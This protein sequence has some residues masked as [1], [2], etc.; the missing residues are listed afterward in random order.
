MGSIILLAVIAP[1]LFAADLAEGWRKLFENKIREAHDIFSEASRSTDRSKAAEAYRGLSEIS[2]F[3]GAERDAAEQLLRAYALDGNR[4]AVAANI[5]RLASFTRSAEGASIKSGYSLLKKLSARTDIYTGL[6]QERLLERYRN[7][8]KLRKARALAAEMGIANQWY[9]IGPFDNI[10]DNGYHTVYPPERRIDLAGRYEGKDGNQVG[11][12]RLEADPYAGWL[13]AEEYLPARGAVNY[14]YTSFDSPAEAEVLLSFGVS[15]IFKVFF[16]STV[17]LQDSTFRNT[18]CDMFMSRVRLRRGVNTLLIKL[19]NQEA[20]TAQVSRGSN[21]LLRFLNLDFTVCRTLDYDPAITT[22]AVSPIPGRGKNLMPVLDTL[23]AALEKGMGKG[24]DNF[25]AAV[26]MVNYLLGSDLTDKAQVLAESWAGRWPK[27]SFW[28]V[29]RYQALVR[30]NKMTQANRELRTAYEL[31]PLSS[32]AWG[33][34]LARLMGTGN[35]ERLSGFFAGSDSSQR[36]SLSGLVARLAVSLK[37]NQQ[38]DLLACVNELGSRYPLNEQAVAI[39][40]DVYSAQGR[41]KEAMRCCRAHLKHQRANGK[42]YL[43]LADLALKQSGIRAAESV[44]EECAEYNPVDANVFFMLAKL[45]YYEKDFE[46]AV[47]MADR[48]L[49]IMPASA[50]A[51]NLKGNILFSSNRPEAARKCFIDVIQSSNDDFSAIENLRVI[52]GK[53]SLDSLVPHPDVLSLVNGFKAD[54]QA[55]CEVGV[56]LADIIDIYRYPG[57]SHRERHFQLVHL[58]T[59]KAIDLWKERHLEFNSNY[60]TLAVNQ[61]YTLKHDGSQVQADRKEATVLFKSLQP[62]DFT[63][64]EWTLSNYYPGGM[65]KHV[66]GSETVHPRIQTRIHQLRFVFPADD[67]IPYQCFGDS[68]TRRNAVVQD[69]RVVTLDLPRHGCGN[70][71]AFAAEDWP[72]KP[73]I[74]YSSFRSWNDIVQWYR[75]LTDMS[76]ST[77]LELVQLADSLSQGVTDTLERLRRV[78]SYICRNIRYS[79]LPFRQSGWIPQIPGDVAA[80][81][82]GDC[83]DMAALGR[84]LLSAMGIRSHLVLLNTDR[85]YFTEHTV[86]GPDFN[87]CI[88]AVPVQAGLRFVDFTDENG[89]FET[90]PPGDQG[91][92]ALVIDTAVMDL[93]VLPTDSSGRGIER[94]VKAT[95]D[96]SGALRMS[97]NTLRRG[98]WASAYR[99]SNRFDSKEERWSGLQKSIAEDYVDSRIDSLEIADIDSLKDSLRYAYAFTSNNVLNSSGNTVIFPLRLPDKLEAKDFPT[100]NLRILPVDMGPRHFSTGLCS[101]SVDFQFPP[102]WKIIGMPKDVRLQGPFGRYSLRFVVNKNQVRCDR[103]A[104]FNLS[105]LIYPSEAFQLKE[106]GN[107]IVKADAVQF[108]FNTGL[109][110]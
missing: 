89:S 30:G 54:P 101:T 60:Q 24:A 105:R 106:F 4:T 8:G 42:I 14:F 91:A 1:A 65:N 70:P 34:E 87:H 86:L 49:L 78:H 11:W 26:L 22:A 100:E 7:D 15:G 64:L 38:A 9:A 32:V 66:W 104:E 110:H 99:N 81:Q 85:H 103:V 98:I 41:I 27:S 56:L 39:L 71:E 79:F 47:A 92:V 36:G 68:I 51:N 88:L 48:C 108:I 55:H 40:A 97:A 107:T 59:Q 75:G 20:G 72:S 29:K 37:T 21:F 73:T 57:R 46:R 63:L 83:K 16:N 2:E 61:A 102:A 33:G 77:S 82:V 76:S 84:A 58:P 31:C 74:T 45:A 10:L 69:Y 28:R 95:L 44:L 12:N 17:V 53:P 43:A 90:L 23:E 52:D 3:R 19:G 109:S 13:F 93:R 25:D 62:G 50:A 94:I 5:I 80:A 35:L 18:G 6:F 96:S 67:T